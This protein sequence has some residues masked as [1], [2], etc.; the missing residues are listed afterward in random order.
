MSNMAEV[1]LKFIKCNRKNY[2]A[3]IRDQTSRYPNN[4]LRK[5]PV[6]Q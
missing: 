6:E 4:F 1:E 3:F 2:D 5:I